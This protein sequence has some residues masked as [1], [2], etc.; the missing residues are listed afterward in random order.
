[1]DT[2]ATPDGR[3]AGIAFADGA[4]AAQGR[5]LVGPTA[6]ALSTTKWSHRKALGGLVHN[7]RFSDAMF[8]TPGNRLAVRTVIETFLRRGGFEIQINMLSADMLRAAQEHPEEHQ[9][10]VV[11]VAGYSDYFTTLTPELQAEVIARTEFETM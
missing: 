11:R 8:A 10:L 4:G 9:D 5:E 2:A 7:A 1:M 6:S 3:L